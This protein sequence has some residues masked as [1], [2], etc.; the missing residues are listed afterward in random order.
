M[1]D[2]AAPTVETSLDLL[3]DTLLKASDD[4][5]AT[6]GTIAIARSRLMGAPH[7][8]S[9]EII[10]AAKRAVDHL[11]MADD[12]LRALVAALERQS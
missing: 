6:H 11:R 2:N 3:G 7:P 10:A 8:A 4:L 12:A 5:T 1:D 9:R